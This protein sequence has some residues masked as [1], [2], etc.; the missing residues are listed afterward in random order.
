MFGLFR[1][2]KPSDSPKQDYEI[3]ETITTKK[4]PINQKKEPISSSGCRFFR[5][6]GL[7]V[8]IVSVVIAILQYKHDRENG[9]TRKECEFNQ[10]SRY[11]KPL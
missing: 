7:I 6:I 9:M 5:G 3:I 11:L 2:R 1:R 10:S 8:A 4:I